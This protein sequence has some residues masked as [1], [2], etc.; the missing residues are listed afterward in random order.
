MS[1]ITA[2][3][4]ITS[5]LILSVSVFVLCYSGERFVRCASGLAHHLRVPALYIGTLVVGF[6]TSLPEIF[7]TLVATQQGNS[8]IAVGNALGSYIANIGM[9]LGAT[10]LI[11]PLKISMA[12]LRKELPI[13]AAALT[14]CIFLIT[15]GHLSPSDGVVLIA[16]FLAFLAFT[17]YTIQTNQQQLAPYLSTKPPVQLNTVSSLSV[18]FS[19]HLL[20]LLGSSY[21]IVYAATEIARILHISQ[22]IIGLTIVAIGTSL[23][24][25]VTSVVSVWKDE[26]DLAMGNIVGSNI[27]CILFILGLAIITTPGGINTE[28]LWPQF[29]MMILTTTCL[30]LFSAKFDKV[31]QIN[32]YEGGLLLALFAVYLTT[33]SL[34]LI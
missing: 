24:E 27:F 31:C 19:W 8:K 26:D 11:K 1:L 18:A 30:W 23:P 21:W 2:Y 22:M 10:A 25:L 20:L 5:L 33:T 16:L 12:V 29:I 6:A 32:R 13:L 34:D 9:V 15:D 4:L 14:C 28:K 7:V 17:F 3:P